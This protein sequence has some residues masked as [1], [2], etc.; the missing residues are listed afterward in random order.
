MTKLHLV[1]AAAL[2]CSLSISAAC[3]KDPE[4]AKREYLRSGDQYSTAKKYKE[5]II[6]YRNAVQ[7]DPKFGE[8]RLKLAEAYEQTGD[9]QNAYGE[10]IRA[11]DLLPSNVAAQ[12]KATNMLLLA[13]Q[14]E[15][16]QA[17]ADKAL[18]VDANSVEA[19]IAKGS[20]LAGLKNM[21]AAVTQIEGAIRLDPGR[22]ASYA[23]LGAIEMARGNRDQAEAA[24]ALSRVLVGDRLQQRLVGADRH[25][26]GERQGAGDGGEDVGP[27]RREDR[28]EVEHADLP[29]RVGGKAIILARALR[30]DP[31]GRGI[32]R[33]SSAARGGVWGGSSFRG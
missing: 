9:L 26:P 21:D 24:R 5:A 25:R 22:S 20:A 3:S 4:V 13:G 6:E 14:F 15:D 2:L 32:C 8:A 1:A 33:A 16:A 12:V 29:P 31:H 30:D 11:A 7:Q 23:N 28:V 27:D 19:Q 18:A 10:Y 17:R